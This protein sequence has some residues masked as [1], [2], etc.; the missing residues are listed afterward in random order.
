MCLASVHDEA[1]G[2]VVMRTAV[3]SVVLGLVMVVVGRRAR[4]RRLLQERVQSLYY[5]ASHV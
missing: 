1:G 2:V 4:S 5:G 3:A